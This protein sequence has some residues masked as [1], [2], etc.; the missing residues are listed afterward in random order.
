MLRDQRA[1]VDRGHDGR[2]FCT[3]VADQLTKLDADNRDNSNQT[4]A[5]DGGRDFGYNGRRHLF[6]FLTFGVQ[7]G[8]FTQG[9]GLSATGHCHP[10]EIEM[11]RHWWF[12][13]N[14]SNQPQA[15][16]W[17]SGTAETAIRVMYQTLLNREK[18]HPAEMHVERFK[19]IEGECRPGAEGCCGA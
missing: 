4:D 18:E 3:G 9:P 11:A 6:T 8:C 2:L 16:N 14:L 7:F 10:K 5:L 12:E 15:R 1:R 13:L 17:L 19:C